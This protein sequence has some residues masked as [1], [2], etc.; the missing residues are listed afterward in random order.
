MRHSLK[1]AAALTLGLILTFPTAAW[2]TV[3]GDQTPATPQEVESA[4]R[5]G[6]IATEPYVDDSLPMTRSLRSQGYAV[7]TIGGQTRYDTSS[8][9]ALDAFGSSTWAIVASGESYADSICSGGL[10]GALECPILLTTKND[11]PGVIRDTLVSLGVQ[12]V[13]VLGGTDVISDG[14]VRQIDGVV[15]DVSRLWGE[16]RYGTQLAVY[17]YGVTHGLWSGDT[18]IVSYGENYADALAVSP[19]SYHIKAPVF[20]ADSTG[21][22]SQEQI[23]ALTKGSPFKKYVITGGM[24]VISSSVDSLL[25]KNGTVVRLGGPTRYETSELV[26]AYAVNEAGMSWNGMAFT[27]GIKPFDALGGGAAQGR[28]GSVLVLRDENTTAYQSKLSLPCSR[29]SSIRFLGGNDVYSGAYKARF[30]L[31]VGYALTDIEGLLIYVDAGHGRLNS[32]GYDPGANGSG[33][34]E[35]DL[36]A[37][38]AQRIA[39]QL[40]N[41]GVQVYLNS[42]NGEYKLHNAEAYNVGAAALVSIHFNASGGTGTESYIHSNHAAYGSNL[43]QS[44]IH[45]R[46]VS[47]LGLRDR[48]RQTEQWAV[49]GGQVPATL[50]EICFIDRPSDMNQYNSRRDQV[51]AA[52]A[53]G[54]VNVGK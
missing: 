54:V 25:K 1:W 36:T 26:A 6:L 19:L 20:F 31:S 40:R 3:E 34:W 41:R 43:L 39:N 52:I 13:I 14:V 7:R 53:D 47:A 32:G 44:S 4:K 12:H 35:H 46:L 37:D 28:L 5:D 9:Q 24:D 50:L 38:L 48:G 8:K 27:S 10:A 51:A 17:D 2:A 11:L 18:A 16:T 15:S 49:C 22:L 42:N 21:A 45:G 29:P 23:G 30:A 33:Y